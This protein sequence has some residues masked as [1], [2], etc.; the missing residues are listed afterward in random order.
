MTG[1]T[2]ALAADNA[3]V[4]L[5]NL[6]K[7]QLT[8]D[9]RVADVVDFGVPDESD[10]R[11]YPRLGLAAAEAIARGEAERGVLVCGTG[12]GMCISANKVDG[13]RATVAHDSY[14]VERSIKS[15]DCQVL[16]MGARVIG[17]ELAKRLV[18]EW[19]G[20]T[21][22]HTSASATKVAY[23]TDYERNH[24]PDSAVAGR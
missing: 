6:L 8:A 23:I 14:S 17:T 11:A 18:D 15:N 1:M 21:F 20:Y 19:L 24:E 22:D 4:Q 3:G 10:D 7:E 16:T 5:K 9:P 12:I 13:V 2:V